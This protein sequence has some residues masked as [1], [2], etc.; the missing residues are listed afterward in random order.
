MC[1]DPASRW[2]PASANSQ[3]PERSL[4]ARPRKVTPH[5]P[6]APVAEAAEGYRGDG[7]KAATTTL[8]SLHHV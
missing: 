6:V 3:A 2:W 1:G 8:V 4:V 5:L 7:S